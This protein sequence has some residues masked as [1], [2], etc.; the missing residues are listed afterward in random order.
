VFAWHLARLLRDSGE[1]VTV[2]HGE[3]GGSRAGL[4]GI[5]LVRVAPDVNDPAVYTYL[6]DRLSDGVA[7]ALPDRT[8]LVYTIDQGA[9]GVGLARQ[10]RLSLKRQPPGLVTVLLGGLEWSDQA[11]LRRPGSLE[12]IAIDFSERYVAKH[13]DAVIA[14]T[15]HI[16]QWVVDHGWDLPPDEYVHILNHPYTTAALLDGGPAAERFRRVVLVG[17]RDPQA[18]CDLLV[19]A[20]L[21]LTGRP[22]LDGLEELVLA[23][24]IPGME[25]GPAAQRL[26]AELEVRVTVA[27]T[28]DP[29]AFRIQLASWAPD[30]LAVMPSRLENLSYAAIEALSIPGLALLCSDGG[31]SAEAFGRAT[32]GLFEPFAPSLAHT[33][34]RWL[35]RGPGGDASLRPGY[36]AEAANRAWLEIHA[37]LLER[38]RRMS[39]SPAAPPTPAIDVCIPYYNLGRY[40]PLTLE[41]LERQTYANFTVIVVDDGSTDEDA[42]QVFDAM[43]AR[44]ADRGWRFETSPNRGLGAARNLAASLGESEVIIFVDADDYAAPSLLERYVEALAASGDDA[45]SCRNYVFEGD[46][47]PLRADGSPVPAR[48]IYA[49]LGNCPEYAMVQNCFGGANLA[50]LRSAFERV[51]GYEGHLSRNLDMEDRD[52]WTRLSLGGYRFDVIPECLFYYRWREDSMLRTMQWFGSEELCLRPYRERLRTVGLERLAWFVPGLL[53]EGE[54]EL[55][56]WKRHAGGCQAEVRE[57]LAERTQVLA[58]GEELQVR[59]EELREERSKLLAR[60]QE[61]EATVSLITA[62]RS[63]RLAAP[64]RAAARRLR[65]LRRRGADRHSLG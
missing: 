13:S 53:A 4:D 54:R 9:M 44:Y 2:I 11:R 40:L 56:W 31:G 57:L 61:L 15:H 6:F 20:L 33:L 25:D 8:A 63:W 30:S 60:V 27:D 41:S 51:G 49:P 3:A 18:S 23:D 55:D 43:R 37:S 36:D 29:E 19:A 21:A 62:S 39:R 1:A 28:S 50:I 64:A 59:G 48:E 26:A 14:P 38:F 32:D 5:D 45:M 22:C 10:R 42:R 47:S 7:P 58:R 16:R 12:A 34:E 24:G 17:G 65:G 52:L 35:M 46:G